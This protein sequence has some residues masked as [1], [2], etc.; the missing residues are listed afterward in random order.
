MKYLMILLYYL[1]IL[2]GLFLIVLTA[3]HRRSFQIGVIAFWIGVI[4]LFVSVTWP[5]LT[6]FEVID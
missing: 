4:A 2:T 1:P 5:S 3:R 6:I